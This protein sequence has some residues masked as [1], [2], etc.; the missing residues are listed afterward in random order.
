MRYNS[1]VK[2]NPDSNLGQVIKKTDPLSFY[3][4]ENPSS[5]IETKSDKGY[6]S[7]TCQVLVTQKK[8]AFGRGL[9]YVITD[10]TDDFSDR[11]NPR[12]II[13]FIAK[14]GYGNIILPPGGKFFFPEFYRI[15]HS[16]STWKFKDN[17]LLGF[18]AL[19]N[20]EEKLDHGL[21]FFYHTRD[22]KLYK[23]HLDNDWW[24]SM[25]IASSECIHFT[26]FSETASFEEVQLLLSTPEALESARDA[27]RANNGLIDQ[28]K[29]QAFARQ[30]AKMLKSSRQL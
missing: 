14:L 8:R 28:K 27:F 17:Q 16:T 7:L 29:A 23:C 21:N 12:T 9:K 30:R 2:C 18:V 15:L 22:H 25:T 26:Q 20:V 6:P 24:K 4:S 13:T 19:V 10:D 11:D 1:I 3:A 5:H